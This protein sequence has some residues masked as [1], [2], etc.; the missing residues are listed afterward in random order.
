MANL[1]ELRYPTVTPEGPFH[2]TVM[3]I[4]ATQTTLPPDQFTS[5]QLVGVNS[6]KVVSS[7][8]FTKLFAID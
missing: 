3:L 5:E 4:S 1:K 6:L 8:S 7:A 2:P